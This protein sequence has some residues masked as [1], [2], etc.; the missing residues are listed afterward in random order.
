MKGRG[1]GLFFR[2][3][4]GFGQL[5]VDLQSCLGGCGRIDVEASRGCANRIRSSPGS[6][7]AS[8]IQRTPGP[9]RHDR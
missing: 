4:D 1:A 8:P 5:R 7:D 3:I 6:N 9:S 2:V